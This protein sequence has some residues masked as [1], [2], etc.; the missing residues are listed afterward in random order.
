[1]LESV[2]IE[3]VVLI[4]K[5]DICFSDR[6]TAF[7]GQT[8]AG[9]SILIDSIG[10]IC[11][12]R[13]GKEFIRHSEKT[14]CVQALFSGLSRAALA[15]CK[16]YDILPDEDGYL[17][18]YRSINSDG[19]NTVKINSKQVPLSLLRDISPML[20]NIHGQHDNQ[21]LLVKEKHREI[22]DRFAENDVIMQEYQKAYV[23]YCSVRDKISQL[24]TDESQK[25]RQLE[26]LDFQIKEISALNL[27]DKDEEEKLEN[28]RKRLLNLEKITHNA[29]IVCES[30]NGS[31]GSFCALDRIDTALSGLSNLSKITDQTDTYIDRLRNI[32]SEII[33][34]AENVQSMLE[35]T[36]ENPSI[37]LDKIEK[38]L[39]HIS[40]AKRKYGGDI[41]SI[42]AFLEN[43]KAEFEKLQNSEKESMLLSKKLSDCAKTLKDVGAKLK[44]SRIDAANIL[45]NSVQDELKFLEMQGAKFKVEITEKKYGKDGADDIEFFVKTNSGSDFSPLSKTASGGELAR[46]MLGIKSVIAR[47]DGIDTLIFDE[48]DTGISGKTSRRIGIK[49]KNIS[50]FCQVLCITHSAQIASLADSHL[51]VEKNDNGTETYTDVIEISGQERIEE[52]ARIIGGINVTDSARKAA[53]ELIGE[54]PLCT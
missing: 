21:Q 9:K 2:H 41:P 7:T 45:Q 30:L 18:I 32:R 51:L 4:K 26:M 29:T 36:S 22:L 15:H 1:M 52:I 49:L 39:D 16:Q 25:A 17:C 50:E 14:A 33:D 10:F 13:T 53:V 35:D 40:R 11:G 28:E 27:K 34:I 3:N 6:F 38:R 48:V 46:I 31:S 8:G 24:V 19:K 20:I 12:A 42:L 54:P 5:L 37:K 47:K 43:A 23:E 44:K